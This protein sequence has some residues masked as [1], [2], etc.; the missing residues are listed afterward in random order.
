M[1]ELSRDTELFQFF[2]EVSI[3][4]QLSANLMNRVLPDGLSISHFSALNHL[5]R[6]GDGITP[7]EL[8]R[9]F[10]VTKPTMTHTLQV[11]SKKG[12]LVLSANPND[13]RSKLVYLTDEGVVYRNKAVKVVTEHLAL[14]SKEVDIER[15]VATI[16]ELQQ[17]RKVLD[18]NR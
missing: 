4:A 3:I 1:S 14:I 9:A 11:L 16:P 6:L 10:Q 7:L 15:V 17:V 5:V 12:F 8:A 18:E 13:A 2:N